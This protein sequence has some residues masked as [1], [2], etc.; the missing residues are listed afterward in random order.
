MPKKSRPS[1]RGLLRRTHSSRAASGSSQTSSSERLA[2]AV[3][4]AV[5]RRHVAWTRKGTCSREAHWR[6]P[7]EP[8]GPLFRRPSTD[9]CSRRRSSR[10][11]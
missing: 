8:P 6:P 9:G 4:S 7:T 1:R 11:T 3:Y 5:R 10:T 2:V